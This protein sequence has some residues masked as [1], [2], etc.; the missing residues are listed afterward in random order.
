[1]YLCKDI[2]LKIIEG[3][4]TVEKKIMASIHNLNFINSIGYH[5][6]DQIRILSNSI[7]TRRRFL[8]HIIGNRSASFLD[9][10]PFIEK[11]NR[12]F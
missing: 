2:Q 9:K 4:L 12:L 3:F 11:L 6:R 5:T 10:Y 1:M 8:N 7:Q